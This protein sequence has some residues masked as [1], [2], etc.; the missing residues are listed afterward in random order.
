LGDILSLWIELFTR[1]LA[2]Q[3]MRTFKLH[4]IE[5]ICVAQQKLSFKQMIAQLRKRLT[6]SL[7]R[8]LS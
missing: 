6:A 4:V 2:P 1:S 8:L 5:V 3:F 7:I